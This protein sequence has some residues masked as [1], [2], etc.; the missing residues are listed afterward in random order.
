MRLSSITW[1][2]PFL[3]RLG[4]ATARVRNPDP[5]TA[6][7]K[8]F[9]LRGN[10]LVFSPGMGSLCRRLRQLGIWAEDLRCVGD[11]WVVRHLLAEQRTGHRCRP[12]IFI[13]HSCGGRYS[14]YAAHALEKAGIPVELVICVDVALAPP[15]PANVRKAVH[16]YL[17]QRRVYPARPLLAAPGSH[18]V[19]QNVDLNGPGSPA[20][21]RGLFHLNITNSAGIQQFILEQVLDA[22]A[23]PH[24][25]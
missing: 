11:R 1:P 14:L 3:V 24:E 19:I 17:T 18:A 8:A 16:L 6:R 5:A 2:F 23:N 4:W 25:N 20:S 7:G 15:V 13:G 21:P 9:L 12:L 10:A 22:V